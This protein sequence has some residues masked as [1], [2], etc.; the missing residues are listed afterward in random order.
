M[1]IDAF[2]YSII[3]TSDKMGFWS[4]TGARFYTA[5]RHI[6]PR[7]T[8]QKYE[9]KSAQKKLRKTAQIEPGKIAQKTS[10]APLLKR[11]DCPPGTPINVLENFGISVEQALFARLVVDGKT[12]VEAYRQ[13]GYSGEGNVAYAAASRLLRNVKVSRYIHAL[14]NERQKRY[15]VELDD[16]ITQLTAIVNA[17]PN[18][19]AQYR[20]VNQRG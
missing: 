16:L 14:R 19:I 10:A 20:R 11:S 1:S 8:A 7:K 17:D 13:A 9:Q 6:K 4:F 3:S 2:Y 5:R 18:E 15:A 12:R